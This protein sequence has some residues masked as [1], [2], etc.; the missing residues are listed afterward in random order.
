MVRAFPNVTGAQ[1]MDLRDYFAAAA[2]QG[3]L[4]KTGH[5][6][7][8]QMVYEAYRVANFMMKVRDETREQT[9]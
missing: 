5:A 2:L 4:A 6:Y 9:S 7:A 3:L 8:D 1:G